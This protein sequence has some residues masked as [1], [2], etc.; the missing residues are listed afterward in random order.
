MRV[1]PT[2]EDML[3]NQ[4]LG[5]SLSLRLGSIPVLAIVPGITL[6]LFGDYG[7]LPA[8]QTYS[9][10]MVSEALLCHHLY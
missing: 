2:R 4:F 7:E 3:F 1:L 10:N 9:W 8:G 6:L 5:F